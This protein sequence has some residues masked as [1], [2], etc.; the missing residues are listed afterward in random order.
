MLED[1]EDVIGSMYERK[2]ESMGQICGMFEI[3]GVRLTQ[4][5]EI[6]VVDS[7]LEVVSVSQVPLWYS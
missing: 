2:V 5:I 1:D 7:C 6:Q 3:L 4:N